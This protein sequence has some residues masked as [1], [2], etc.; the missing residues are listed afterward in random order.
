MTIEPR[1]RTLRRA[2]AYAASGLVICALL[3]G[4]GAVARDKLSPNDIRARLGDI[5][6]VTR[7]DP[8]GIVATADRLSDTDL[9]KGS[10]L[11]AKLGYRLRSL[12]L[13]GT[14]VANIDVLKGLAALRSLD[15]ARTPVA[16]IDALEGLTA[17]QGLDL[18]GT[19]V[20]NVGALARLSALRWLDL[21]GTPVAHVEALCG[22]LRAAV[23]RSTGHG[24]H[25][26][27][28]AADT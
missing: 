24:G 17:L 1:T 27:R 20:A 10:S 19:R 16:N 22:A 2:G 4:T 28:A 6:I 8:S 15:L 14:Q 21:S 9:S 25:R 7:F 12:D 18:S 5:G 11:L 26:C 3:D 13:S 23:A